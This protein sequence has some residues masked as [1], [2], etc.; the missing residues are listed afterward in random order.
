MT[1][2]HAK[3]IGELAQSLRMGPRELVV[4]AVRLGA[5]ASG[6]AAEARRVVATTSA[7]SSTVQ[8]AAAL[9]MTPVA[10]FAQDDVDRALAATWPARVDA[11]D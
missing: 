9:L 5:S 8:T 2:F 6:A 10:S 1:A 11:D 4:A 3:R 7:F